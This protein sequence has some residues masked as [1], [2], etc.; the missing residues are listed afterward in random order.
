MNNVQGA[1]VL[2]VEDDYVIAT[3]TMEMLRSA[4]AV[5]VG[6]FSWEDEALAFA[7]DAANLLDLAILDVDLHGKPSYRVADALAA[8]GVPVI[9]TTGFGTDALA[10]A[11][12]GCPRLEKPV[13]D[14]ALIAALRLQRGLDAG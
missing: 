4:G 14:Q 11:Y 10:P 3:D 2:V 1:R 6:P 8:R 5:P 13:S 12:R 9:F 7:S